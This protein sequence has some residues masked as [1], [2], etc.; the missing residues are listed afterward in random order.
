MKKILLAVAAVATMASCSQNEE[1]ENVGQKAEIKIGTTVKA[2]SRA[3]VMD[4][5]TFQSFEVSSFILDNNF[6]FSK[7][8]LGKPYMDGVLFTGVKGSW[9]TTDQNN[10]YWPT[11][12]NVQFFGYPKDMTLNIAETGYPTLNFSIGATSSDQTDLVVA[13]ENMSKPGDNK[14][15]LTFKHILTKINFSYKPEAGYKYEISSIKIK[16]VKGGAAIYTYNSDVAQGSWTEG[17]EVTDGYTYPVTP[18]ADADADGYYTLD[19]ENGS[20]MLL[21]QELSGATIEITYKTTR[22]GG[23]F[24]DSTKTVNIPANSKW[25]ASK[26]IRYKLTL[27]AGVDKV[28]LDTTVGGWTDETVDPEATTPAV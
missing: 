23:T 14:A 4:D 26:S 10:Y 19:S 11:D 1:F 13:A 27:P 15:T 20:L 17:T 2:T 28:T 6:D 9:T 8:K 7:G 3:V 24:F 16:G 12:K 25:E 21:P 18:A 5:A 22:D